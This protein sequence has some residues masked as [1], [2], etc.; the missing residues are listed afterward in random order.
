MTTARWTSARLPWFVTALGEPPGGEG[1]TR[2]RSQFELVP[3]HGSD[4]RPRWYEN[5]ALGVSVAIV[6]GRVDSISFHADPRHGF[7]G[8]HTPCFL[9]A[10]WGMSRE[11]VRALFGEPDEVREP[12]AAIEEMAHAG[13]DRYRCDGFSVAV[14]YAASGEGLARIGF[15]LPAD[16]DSVS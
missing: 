8:P 12:Y 4:R 11:Q 1:L 14:S 9:G 16:D 15:E 2:L 5:D 3:K 10:R 6:R 7:G 13:I